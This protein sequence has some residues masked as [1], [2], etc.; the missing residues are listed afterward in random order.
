MASALHPA[1][2]NYV[3][4]TTNGVGDFGYLVKWGAR[5]IQLAPTMVRHHYRSRANVDRPF[6]VVDRHDTF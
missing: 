4:F 1:I 2:A 3:D 5:T 6:C